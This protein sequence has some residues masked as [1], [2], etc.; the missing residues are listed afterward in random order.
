MLVSGYNI[1]RRDRVTRDHGG[2]CTYIRGSIGYDV[3]SDLMDENF[4]VLW[5]KIRPNRLPRGI[6]SIIVGTVY[7][8]PSAIDFLILDYLYESLSKIEAIF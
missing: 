1:I 7:H 4:E 3:L 8:P 2:I 6:P 5:V